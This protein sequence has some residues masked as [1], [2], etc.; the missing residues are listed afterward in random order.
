MN[1]SLSVKYHLQ[2]YKKALLIFYVF[3][4]SIFILQLTTGT[5]TLVINDIEI[6]SSGLEV[7]SMIFM[8]VAGLNSFR[9]PFLFFLVNG[10]SRKTMFKSTVISL[11]VVSGLMALVD[12]LSGLVFH[13][14]ADYKT[15][16]ELMYGSRYGIDAF[17]F[18]LQFILERFAWLYSLYVLASMVGYFVTVLY[19]R[20]DLVWKYIVSIGVPV[21][22]IF[23][24]PIVDSA[25]GGRMSI[26][27]AEMF[28]KSMGL[29][30]DHNPYPAMLSF[31]CGTVIYAVLG[32]ML[33]R[34]AVIKKS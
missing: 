19:Y 13:R 11:I 9:V 21:L 29:W 31:I 28:L 15:I 18:N 27:F 30:N 24:L 32:Y 10:V 8:F 12:T 16:F 1:V 7:A 22:F 33:T 6:S 4:G 34:K 14:L 26:F 17:E 23:G 5:P 2:E 25:T 20:M 3:Y